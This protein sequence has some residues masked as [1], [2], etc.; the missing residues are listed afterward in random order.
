MFV[1]ASNISTPLAFLIEALLDVYG[2]CFNKQY[3]QLA[4]TLTKDVLENF[5]DKTDNMFYFTSAKQND[6]ILR[7]KDIFDNATPSGNST[8]AKNLMRLGMMLDND[9]YIQD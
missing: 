1:S 7:K 2:I 9:N 6:I 4:E 5:L 3:L 8:M